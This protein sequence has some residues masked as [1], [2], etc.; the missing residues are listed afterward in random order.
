M[1]NRNPLIQGLG[2]HEALEHRGGPMLRVGSA[3]VP[4]TLKK[5]YVYIVRIF[6]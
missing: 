1:Q 5:N 4:A 3:R 2:S 6:V